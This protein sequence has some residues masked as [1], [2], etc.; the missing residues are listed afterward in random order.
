MLLGA[1]VNLTSAQIT[2]KI[3]SF[4]TTFTIDNVPITVTRRKLRS[5]AASGSTASNE[6]TLE[7]ADRDAV[8]AAFGSAL[9]DAI[10]GNASDFTGQI[11]VVDAVR[12]SVGAATVVDVNVTLDTSISF[13]KDSFTDGRNSEVVYLED[14]IQRKIK[15]L[16]T[17]GNFT[18]YLNAEATTSGS[19]AF[20][21]ASVNRNNP[22]FGTTEEE[23]ADYTA[24]TGS[25]DHG[26]PKRKATKVGT[27]SVGVV[28]GV[29]LLGLSFYII[30]FFRP[31]TTAKVEDGVVSK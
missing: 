16:V 19:T 14:T 8:T 25:F 10:G 30:C 4:N 28:I 22:T 2:Y 18:S 1:C 15:D 12:R 21:A 24:V 7:Q 26:D 11:H 5:L 31:P 6:V 27:V 20:A 3:L 13:D 29:I 23:S 9:A 17:S